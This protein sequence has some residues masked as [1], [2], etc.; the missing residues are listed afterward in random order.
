M[1]AWVRHDQSF[2]WLRHLPTGQPPSKTHKKAWH[3]QA[4]NIPCSCWILTRYNALQLL[5][6]RRRD[7]FSH[8]QQ[9]KSS[10][11]ICVF[12]FFTHVQNIVAVVVVVLLLLLVVVVV[13]LLLVVVVVVAKMTP[14]LS[15]F[16]SYPKHSSRKRCMNFSTMASP[17]CECWWTMLDSRCQ[18]WIVYWL[19]L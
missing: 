6:S 1:E 17:A 4:S 5:S 15:V 9:S 11:F 13:L 3:F 16:F 18:M 14:L 19:E 7:V 10:S 2:R 8:P 12:D